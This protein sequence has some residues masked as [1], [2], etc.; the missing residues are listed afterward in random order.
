MAT[1]F[2]R[3]MEELQQQVIEQA[4]ALYSAKV[5]EEFYNPKNLGR[6][7]EPDAHGLVHGWCGDTMEIYLRLDGERIQEA[8]FMTDGCGPSVACGSKLTTMIEGMSVA[9]ASKIRPKDLLEALDGLPEENAHCA[10]LAVSTLQNALL[11]WR[12]EKDGLPDG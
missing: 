6:M 12:V 7:R 4:R 8:A 5:V 3:A 9:E 10:E 1:D 2:D 11:N